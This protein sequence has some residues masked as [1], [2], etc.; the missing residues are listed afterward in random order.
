MP[1]YKDINTPTLSRTQL[2][3]MVVQLE[4]SL[5][6][7]EQQQL[8]ATITQYIPLLRP[9]AQQSS[10]TTFIQRRMPHIG[11]DYYND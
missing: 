2:L 11:K 10:L 9:S 1:H 7:P 8:L 5:H 6:T 4:A 3:A